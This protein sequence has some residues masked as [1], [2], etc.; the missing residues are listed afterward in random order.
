VAEEMAIL[1]NPATYFTEP[2]DA[3]RRVKA[4]NH[5]PK[6]LAIVR[7]LAQ[8]REASAQSRDMPRSRILKDD[9]L[10]EI[11]TARPKTAEELGKLRLVHREARR[12]EVASAIIAAVAE[13]ED[14]PEEERPTLP[15]P[16]H[17]RQGSAAIADILRVFLK[18]R[19]EKLGIASKL[20][21]SS[22]DL[23]A[24]AGE[25]SPDLPALKGWRRDVFGDDALRVMAGELA[26]V[27][28]PGG[29]E[30]I[31]VE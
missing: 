24:L 14:C 21:A 30:L 9:A 7:A 5:N 18:A 17:R 12:P 26:L 8:W 15:R 22:A 20:I 13:G 23:E 6:Y 3:W 4:R 29:V 11:A 19:A 25:D 27:A 1:T 31:A 28:R 10:L 16:P 2:A